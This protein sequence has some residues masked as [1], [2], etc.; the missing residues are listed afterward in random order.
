M[1][2]QI[3]VTDLM[4]KIAEST[5]HVCYIVDDTLYVVDLGYESV[6]FVSIP[7]YEIINASVD[8]EYPISF[9]ETSF[10]KKVV[11]DDEWPITTQDENEKVRVD[12]VSVGSSEVVDA[13]SK[14]AVDNR[15]YLQAILN[16]RKKAKMSLTVNDVN[17]NYSI[18]T[19]VKFSREEEQI[20]YDMIIDNISYN[21][22]NLQT[23]FSGRG[24]ISVI[25][26]EGIFT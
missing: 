18:G 4:G 13:V 1:N 24:T 8:S 2:S 5:N 23:Q 7:S 12:N 3:K 15:K 25:E 19:R 26:R 10:T 21:F 22:K 16:H 17:L 20:S 6:N 9:I 11:Y 14:V